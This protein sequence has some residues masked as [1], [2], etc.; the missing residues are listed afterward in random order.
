MKKFK[1]YSFW[2]ALMGAIVL[3]IE[4]LSAIFGFEFNK[5]I[6]ESVFLSVCGILVVLGIIVKDSSNQNAS[7]E[8]FTNEA[9]KLAESNQ[10]QDFE[11]SED[12]NMLTSDASRELNVNLENSI[13]ENIEK[14]D[15]NITEQINKKL[16]D[17]NIEN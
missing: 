10:N 6:F 1:T 17:K 8:D 9:E 15:E 11:E 7:T 12:M 14:K 3:L 5:T 16:D 4:N 2:I 13:I